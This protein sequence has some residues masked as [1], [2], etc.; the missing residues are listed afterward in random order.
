[1]HQRAGKEDGEQGRRPLQEPRGAPP[2]IAL[3]AC[4]AQSRPLAAALG[5][6]GAWPLALAAG[7]GP[8][9]WDLDQLAGLGADT[10][11]VGSA[12]GDAARLVR[13]AR[14]AAAATDVVVLAL[15]PDSSTVTARRLLD[16]GADDVV[17]PPHSAAAILLRRGIALSRVLERPRRERSDRI[18]LGSLELD[19]ISRE[20]VQDGRRAHLSGREF[21]LMVQLGRAE[22]RVV[23]RDDLIRLVWG[24]GHGSASALDATVHRLRRSLEEDG[25]PGSIVETVRGVGYRLDPE[26]VGPDEG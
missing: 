10:I 19:P 3:V 18:R 9:F 16:A 24:S 11:L 17:A 5:R 20:V 6:H 15:V 1:M 14:R 13:M 4:G 8:S 22:G 23:R 26:V 12:G 7:G 21:D 2:R 25:L